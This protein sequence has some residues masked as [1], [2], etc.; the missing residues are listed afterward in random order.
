M[1]SKQKSETGKC[2]RPGCVTTVDSNGWCFG[3]EAFICDKHASN[4]DAGG[5]GHATADHWLPSEKEVRALL[6]VAEA[7]AFVETEACDERCPPGCCGW[8]AI[9]DAL[10]AW[11]KVR[12]T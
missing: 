2:A 1:G 3:C 6:A 7:A 8:C 9:A 4:A 5:H 10:E 11:R 12:G